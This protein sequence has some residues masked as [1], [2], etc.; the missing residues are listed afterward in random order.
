MGYQASNPSKELRKKCIQMI[1]KVLIISYRFL[2]VTTMPTMRLLRFLKYLKQFG[3]QIVVLTTKLNAENYIK[4]SD[5]LLLDIVKGIKVYGSD[6]IGPKTS[7]QK[8]VFFENDSIITPSQLNRSI[9]K[10]L[11]NLARAFLNN[12]LFETEISWLPFA[13]VKGIKIIKS[14]NIKLIYT[15]GPPFTA[16]LIGYLLKIISNARLIAEIRD[17]IHDDLWRDFE[18]SYIG[19]RIRQHIADRIIRN[20]DCV[21]TTSEGIKRHIL[22]RNMIP[23]D[24][25][26]IIYNGFDLPT[27]IKDKSNPFSHQINIVYTGKLYGPRVISPFLRALK[28]LIDREPGM[29]TKILFH[30]AG[31]CHNENFQKIVDSLRIKG[32]V[33]YYGFVAQPEVLNL[34]KIADIFLLIKAPNDKISI[35]GKL[36]EYLGVKKPILALVPSDSEAANII[37]RSQS[38]IITSPNNIEDIVK[39]LG[40]IVESYKNGDFYSNEYPQNYNALN[41]TKKL[42]SIFYEVVNE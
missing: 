11:K 38:G 40:L 22:F 21:I 20:A 32:N 18:Y 5:K 36:F 34:H 16:N 8:K 14:E 31:V 39:G 25:I 29:R 10:H 30:F 28:E 35:P 19:K 9:N 26:R 4:T 7:F 24:K 27:E 2:P 12:Y 41:L 1:K 37:K 42:E 6:Y 3:W 23:K 13:L 33:K 17:T 15:S